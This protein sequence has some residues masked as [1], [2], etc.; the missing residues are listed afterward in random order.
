VKRGQ[1]LFTI[2]SPDLLQAE[3]TESDSLALHVDQKVNVNVA[4][5]PDQVFEGRIPTV[6]S[7]VDPNARRVLVRSEVADPKHERRAVFLRGAHF[8]AHWPR[9]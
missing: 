7:M 2:D 6:G 8:L 4:A 3:S 5:F 9:V 1:T